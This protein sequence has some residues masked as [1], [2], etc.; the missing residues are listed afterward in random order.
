MAGGMCGRGSCMVVEVHGKGACVVGGMH[1]RGHVWQGACMHDRR[2]G[3]CS[4]WFTSYWNAFLLINVLVGISAIT[5]SF[6]ILNVLKTFL[7]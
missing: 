6:E 5:N 3:H 4:R 7:E 1:G 2:D